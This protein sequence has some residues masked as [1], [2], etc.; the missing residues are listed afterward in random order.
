[1][2]AVSPLSVSTQAVGTTF[3]IQVFVRGM[4]QFNGWDIQIVSDS[5]VINATSLDIT[6]NILSSSGGSAVEI[7]H[8][9]NGQGSGCNG[10]DVKGIVHS[11]YGNTAFASG[12]GLLFTITYQVVT[13]LPYTAITVRNDLISSSNPSGVP[14]TTLFGTYGVAS[15]GGGGSRD[16]NL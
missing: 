12:D 2:I 13:T 11:A 6:G 10:S 1:M 16:M 3:T 14:H 9:V 5:A 15:V 8:C 4:G 7:T